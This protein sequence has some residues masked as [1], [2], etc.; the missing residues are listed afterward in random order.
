MIVVT[1]QS[2]DAVAARLPSIIEEAG[3]SELYGIDMGVQPATPPVRLLIAKNLRAR[4][5]DVE[6][7]VRK[8]TETLKWRREFNPLS[9]AYEEDHGSQYNGLAYITTVGNDSVCWSLFGVLIY[10]R[11]HYCPS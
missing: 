10:R 3:H 5:N 9:A 1:S 4:N 7:T 8:L 11:T 2:I 6:V